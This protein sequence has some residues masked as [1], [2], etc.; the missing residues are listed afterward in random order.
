MNPMKFFGSKIVGKIKPTKYFFSLLLLFLFII[1]I[2][3]KRDKANTDYKWSNQ[4]KT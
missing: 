2:M 4:K 1:G 3:K